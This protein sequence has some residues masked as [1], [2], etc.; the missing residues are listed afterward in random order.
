MTKTHYKLSA[1]KR[2]ETLLAQALSARLL[3]LPTRDILSAAKT[4][5]TAPPAMLVDVVDILSPGTALVVH[6][7]QMRVILQRDPELTTAVERAYRTFV[8]WLL[9][10]Q[11]LPNIK[12]GEGIGQAR[13]L[14]RWSAV[15]IR[16]NDTEIWPQLVSKLEA[17]RANTADHR[18]GHGLASAAM[19]L[20][21]NTMFHYDNAFT[22]ARGC[23]SPGGYGR[24]YP[25][26]W[27]EKLCGLLREVVAKADSL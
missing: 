22:R 18:S 8:Y 12:I 13:K 25:P 6:Y 15:A 26:E 17:A 1:A 11:V 5:G 24:P 2:L 20:S 7:L 4:I 19:F 21:G 14:V 23:C 9:T 27:A 3:G 16:D 10:D